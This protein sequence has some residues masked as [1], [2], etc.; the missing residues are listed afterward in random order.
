VSWK[1][2]VNKWQFLLSVISFIL[3]FS[4]LYQLE[5]IFIDMDLKR[6]FCFPF[7]IYCGYEYWIYRDIFYTLIVLAFFL[8]LYAIWKWE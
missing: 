1:N 4:S 8:L 3:L 5:I 2:T 6:A 7:D